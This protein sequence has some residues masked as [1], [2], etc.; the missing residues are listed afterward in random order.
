M[1]TLRKAEGDHGRR[2]L[3]ETPKTKNPLVGGLPKEYTP[4][5]YV[6]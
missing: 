3:H 2:R 4:M 6:P 1:F 5:S